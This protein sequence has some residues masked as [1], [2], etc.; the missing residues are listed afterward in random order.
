MYVKEQKGVRLKCSKP[1]V[2]V[3]NWPRMNRRPLMLT[4][5]NCKVGPSRIAMDELAL[6]KAAMQATY[7]Q[8]SGIYELG[9]Y[10][11]HAGHVSRD[12]KACKEY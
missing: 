12:T 2:R 10:S 11:G 9:Y 8:I 5:V 3:E 1:I 4:F 7:I 6:Q